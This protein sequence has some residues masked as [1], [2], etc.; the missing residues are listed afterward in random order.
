MNVDV[1]TKLEDNFYR[2]SL[3]FL[4]YSFLNKLNIGHLF[5]LRC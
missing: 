2:L 5:I 4:K 3:D 1:I